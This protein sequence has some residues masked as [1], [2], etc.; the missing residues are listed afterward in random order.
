MFRNKVVYLSIFISLL[1]I[2]NVF[3]TIEYTIRS[4]FTLNWYYLTE[5]SSGFTDFWGADTYY[6]DYN[7]DGIADYLISLK[8]PSTGAIRIFALDT[9]VSNTVKTYANKTAGRDITSQAGTFVPKYLDFVLPEN[10][11]DLPDMW[12]IGTDSSSATNPNLNYTKFIFWKLDKNNTSFPTITNFNITV[13]S[14]YQPVISWLSYSYNEDSYP[15]ILIYYKYINASNNFVV[16]LYSGTDGSLI[17]SKSFAKDGEDPG[18]GLY[19][20]VGIPDLSVYPLHKS[21]GSTPSGDFD[22]DGKP[23]FLLYYT[24]GKGTFPTNYSTCS[25][26]TILKKDGTH[27]S[28][29]SGWERIATLSMSMQTYSCYPLG[30]FNNDNYLD[31]IFNLSNPAGATPPP[32]FFGYDLK[33]KTTLFQATNSDFGCGTDLMFFITISAYSV[34]SSIFDDI[35][36]DS[37]KDLVTYNL[38]QAPNIRFGIFNAYDGNGANK[39]RKMWLASNSNYSRLFYPAGD[40]NNDGH[41]DFALEKDP[42]TPGSILSGKISWNIGEFC[43]GTDNYTTGREFTYSVPYS[44]TYNSEDDDFS[45]N[46]SIIFSVGDMGA[47]SANDFVCCFNYY[48]DKDNNDS[49]DR[50]ASEIYTYDNEVG[51]NPPNTTAEMEIRAINEDISLQ[52]MLLFSNI[53]EKNELVDNNGDGKSNDVVILNERSIFAVS[54]PGGGGATQ[55][56]AA[57]IIDIILG[58]HIPTQ[59]EIDVNDLNQDGK[60]DIADLVMLINQKRK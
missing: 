56:S 29:Y 37:W 32:I 25:D 39:G 22:D 41:G 12:L 4:G 42:A 35:D 11:T 9:S 59:Q 54:Y 53:I 60:I 47:T 3:A 45:A 26:L 19:S 30:Q 55:P 33:N 48:W 52:S 23:D 28:P 40:Y 14:Q 24:F 15:D 38:F 2:L 17:W 18:T 44:F 57:L 46:T 58:K 49:I 7:G 6:K 13:N 1:L 36:G 50:S 21:S 43:V 20:T 31:V 8:N 34:T 27:L 16:S 5:P 51:V 10:S